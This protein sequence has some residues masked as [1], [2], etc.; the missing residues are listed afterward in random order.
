MRSHCK[1]LILNAV[2]LTAFFMP[3]IGVCSKPNSVKLLTLLLLFLL[4]FVTFFTSLLIFKSA[5]CG[6]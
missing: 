6:Y 3:T 1:I 5:I 2:N 4:A